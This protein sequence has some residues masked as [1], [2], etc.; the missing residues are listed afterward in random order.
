MCFIEEVRRDA[1]ATLLI[2]TS[3][4]ARTT[5]RQNFFI[6]LNENE[7][8]EL[9][10]LDGEAIAA[11]LY[12]KRNT[13]FDTAQSRVIS[14]GALAAYRG[15][16]DNSRE[17]AKRLVSKLKKLGLLED[18]ELRQ[19]FRLP[20]AHTKEQRPSTLKNRDYNNS[21]TT[22]K[23]STN[24]TTGQSSN[25]FFEDE[26]EQNH[27]SEKA[28]SRKEPMGEVQRLSQDLKERLKSRRWQFANAETPK[29]EGFLK[30]AAEWF[31]KHHKSSGD[32]DAMLDSVEAKEGAGVRVVDLCFHQNK[33]D[34]PISNKR[35]APGR[36][37]LV[38]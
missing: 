7:L 32:I 11:Y 15:Y 37:D 5:M 21:T 36:G 29:N 20:Y 17:K 6:T 28:S 24:I 27:P 35:V 30:S 8:G 1:F 33:A 16:G 3:H 31:I 18:T 13:D 10:Q 14:Y 34:K 9:A 25:N 19:V 2:L 26:E 23:H 38:I 4:G 12:I 22:K